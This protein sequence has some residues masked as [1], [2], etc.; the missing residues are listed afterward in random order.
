MRTQRTGDVLTSYI[1]NVEL[2]SA[3]LFIQPGLNNLCC[4]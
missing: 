3:L 1:V 2:L 4:I